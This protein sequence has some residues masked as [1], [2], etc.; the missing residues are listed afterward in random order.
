MRVLAFA[1]GIFTGLAFSR[2]P[3][4]VGPIFTDQPGDPDGFAPRRLHWQRGDL[5]D[6]EWPPPPVRDE[7]VHIKV[8]LP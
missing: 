1:L 3:H 8:G 4:Y 2:I 6:H 7:A 5:I